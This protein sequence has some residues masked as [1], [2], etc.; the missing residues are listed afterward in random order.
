MCLLS[1]FTTIQTITIDAP[2]VL[3]LSFCDLGY[4]LYCSRNDCDIKD[5]RRYKLLWTAGSVYSPGSISGTEFGWSIKT[6]ELRSAA[7]KA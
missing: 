3:L 4:Y 1:T 2:L 6:D 5:F 7:L